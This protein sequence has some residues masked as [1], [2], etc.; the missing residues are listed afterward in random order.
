MAEQKELNI[1]QCLAKIR[2]QV[3]VIQKDKAGYNYKYVSDDEILARISGLMEK[4][5]LNLIP[6]IVPGTLMVTPYLTKKTRTRRDGQPYEENV[7]EIIVYAD[8]VFEWVNVDNPEEHVEVPWV[9][10]GHQDDAS[11]SLGS[12]LTYCTRY[13]LLKF[14]NVATPD[15][16]PDK[17]RGKQRATSEA[18]EKM[19]TKEII[20]NFDAKVKAYL[21]ANPTS[22]EA[23][24]AMISKYARNSDYF[25][26]TESTLASK[27]AQEFEETF[28]SKKKE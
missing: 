1:H 7:N 13:F 4:Y 18:E 22:A 27:M 28:V 10:I 9:V 12:G 19:I 17:W 11:Q 16:D 23:V 6:K 3:E 5:H 14:F 20:N 21:S 2:K 8:M 26:I 24:K 15:D 25:K